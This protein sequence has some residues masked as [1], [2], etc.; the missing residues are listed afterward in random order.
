MLFI[1][2][3]VIQIVLFLMH[4]AVYRA[5]SAAF[6]LDL[7]WLGW[8]FAFLSV[9]FVTSSVLAHTQC[10]KFVKWFYRLSTYWFGLLA[11]LY[12]ATLAFYVL[13]VFIFARNV[14]VS[15]AL[16]GTICFGGWFLVHTYAT[17][18]TMRT[19][20]I[21]LDIT[22]SNLPEQWRGKKI[23]FASDT[24]FGAIWGEKSAAKTVR[25]I[26]AESPEMVLIGGDLFDGVK[27]DSQSLIEPF[28][29]LHAPQGTYFVSGNHEYIGNAPKV[30]KEI[31]DIGIRVLDN[32]MVNING[33]QL[34]GVDWKST[35]KAAEF[36]KALAAMKINRSLPSILMK[37]EPNDLAAAEAAGISLQLSGHTHHGQIWPLGY[38]TANM[39]NGF[40][41]GLKKFKEMMVY[42]S[43]GVGT[44]GMPL[45]F[46]TKSEII[47]ITLH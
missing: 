6:G 31:K 25:L 37:H 19:E 13:E 22:L 32:E 11:F 40:D 36:E 34:V 47:V 20:V 46:L 26:A 23:V 43:S 33:L 10:N 30:I 38:I 24:H 29:S 28:R 2:F 4:A 7:P 42:T 45:K 41:Y 21:R 3:T 5:I 27:C 9:T 44:W 12:E 16:L 1:V 17:W 35:H 39:Y 14:Y 18:R 8:I 15:P